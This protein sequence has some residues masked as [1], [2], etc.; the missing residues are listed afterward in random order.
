MSALRAVGPPALLSALLY[1]GA[2]HVDLDRSPLA[3]AYAGL[4]SSLYG[5]RVARAD[6]AA[7]VTRRGEVLELTTACLY[8]D[9]AAAAA[10]WVVLAARRPSR[11]L[12]LCLAFLVASQGANLLRIGLTL[13]L[14]DLG[15]GWLAAHHL[16][17]LLV[18]YGLLC[19]A[20]GCFLRSRGLAGWRWLLAFAALGIAWDL[21]SVLLGPRG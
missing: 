10:P 9:L 6:G 14:S 11:G 21:G 7:V 4:I 19:A 2:A 8:L 16:V 12:L 5:S 13:W 1:A 18:W 3:R 17:D 20:I 15:A